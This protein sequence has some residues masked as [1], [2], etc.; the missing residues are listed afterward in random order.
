MYSSLSPN[1]HESIN[2]LSK[3]EG[4]ND[5]S[6]VMSKIRTYTSWILNKYLDLVLY[7][8]RPVYN[9]Q[10]GF[11][12]SLLSYNTQ[13]LFRYKNTNV[14]HSNNLFHLGLIDQPSKGCLRKS[15]NLLIRAFK[16]DKIKVLN[17]FKEDVI[18]LNSDPKRLESISKWA[19]ELRFEVMM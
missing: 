9:K 5:I 3:N 4:D 2:I 1:E 15:R 18:P 16:N 7:K 10:I 19:I 14:P 8:F 6:S 12:P 17:V 11:D 13:V